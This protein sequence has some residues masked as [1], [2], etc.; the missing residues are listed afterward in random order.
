M[1]LRKAFSLLE[2]MVA[3]ALLSLGLVALLQVQAR[4]TELAIR[5]RE[6]TVATMLARAKLY[7]CEELLRKNGFSVGD[8]NESGTFDDEGYPTV[9][10]EC[11]AYKPELPVPDSGDIEQAAAGTGAGGAVGEADA[12]GQAPDV[13]MQF[14]AP[15]LAQVSGV[16]GES[17]RELA[18]VVRWG[19]ADEPQDLVVVTHVVDKGPVTQIAGMLS[20]QCGGGAP[21]GGGGTSGGAPP[22]SAGSPVPGVPG[23]PGLPGGGGGIK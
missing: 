14:L 6:M 23:A 4:S 13:G 8:F 2:V 5:A 7:D 11:H 19:T 22:R 15:V 21:G 12:Q 20:G 1:S 16:L 10:W 9:R 3:V 17:L 18:V